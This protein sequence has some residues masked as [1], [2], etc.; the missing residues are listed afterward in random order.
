MK[1]IN[2]NFISKIET[3]KDI[4]AL[5][6]LAVI[7]VILFHF[8]KNILVL[9]IWVLMFFLISG[10]VISNL[11]YSDFSNNTFSFKKFSIRDLEELF[12]LYYLIQSLFR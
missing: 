6:G 1:K 7:S 8:D 10:F 2:S 5:R 3:R 11:I 12:Q 9:D 4:Q